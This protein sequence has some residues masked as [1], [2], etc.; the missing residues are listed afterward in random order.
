[1]PVP[2]YHEG[3]I[4]KVIL[5]SRSGDDGAQGSDTKSDGM[6][7]FLFDL[8]MEAMGAVQLDGLFHAPKSTKCEGKLDL[9]LRTQEPL[10]PPM[11]EAMRRLYAR[12][13]EQ[14]RVTGELG[15]QDGAD[16]WVRPLDEAP[17]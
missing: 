14:A 9:I 4:Q 6:T 11:R 3:Q 1:M 10:S 13:L 5:H 12:G 7:R 17:N 8:S 15:F 16:R 2:L